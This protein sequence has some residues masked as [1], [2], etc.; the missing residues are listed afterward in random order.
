MAQVQ[1]LRCSPG[2]RVST[3]DKGPAAKEASSEEKRRTLFWVEL[4]ESCFKFCKNG[5]EDC[6]GSYARETSVVRWVWAPV[7]PVFPNLKWRAAEAVLTF[8]RQH[9]EKEKENVEEKKVE[10]KEE[11]RK[12]N[13]QNQ[14]RQVHRR[15]VKCCRKTSWDSFP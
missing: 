5:D 12:N 14:K 6:K 8:R 2:I 4:W 7:R 1:G 3:A 13:S 10:E 11:A 15:C 9:P